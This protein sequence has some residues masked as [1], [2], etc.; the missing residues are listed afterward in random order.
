M[1]DEI[2]NAVNTSLRSIPNIPTVVEENTSFSPSLGQPYVRTTIIPS[3]PLQISRGDDRLLQYSSLIQIDY[4]KQL[5]GGSTEA[6]VDTIVSHFNNVT[7]RD[8]GLPQY[9]AIVL[10]TWRNPANKEQNWYRM[11]VMLRVQWFSE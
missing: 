8:L 4:F 3:E 11:P 6:M 10:R 5:T 9:E 7:N 2:I 1:Y